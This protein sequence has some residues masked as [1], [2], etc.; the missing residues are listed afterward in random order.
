MSES[1]AKELIKK[2]GSV[3]AK[4]T[5]F[6]SY[7]NVVRS[8]AQLSEL[9][10]TELTV[11]L[12]KIENLYSIYDTLQSDLEMIADDPDELY[13]ERTVR[14]AVLQCDSGCSTAR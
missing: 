3:K 5:Q 12:S 6:S 2:R 11:R 9:Q 14:V 13:A 7:L 10:I 1:K 8:S 4:I